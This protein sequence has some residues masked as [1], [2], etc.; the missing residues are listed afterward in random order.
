MVRSATAN[1][2]AQFK[3]KEYS[4]EAQEKRETCC[5]RLKQWTDPMGDQR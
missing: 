4:S 1:D 2:F 5:C 3:V